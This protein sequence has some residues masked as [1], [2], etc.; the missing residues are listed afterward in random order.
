[1][2]KCVSDKC[3][4]IKSIEIATQNNTSLWVSLHYFI[5]TIDYMSNSYSAITIRMKVDNAHNNM[6]Y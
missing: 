1:L 5:K 4:I 6:R 2:F 3:P